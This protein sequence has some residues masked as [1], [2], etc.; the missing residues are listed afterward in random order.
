MSLNN[1]KNDLAV[2]ALNKLRLPDSILIIPDGNGRWAKKEGL[3]IKKGHEEGGRAIGQIL[4]HFVKLNTKIMG[5]WG[6][7]EDNWKRDKTEI[8]NIMRVIES[9]I[10]S[11]LEKLIEN[12]VKFLL[13]G[14]TKR[15]GDEYPQVLLSLKKAEEQTS[16]FEKKTLALFIDYGQRFQLEEFARE[17]KNDPQS[18]TIDLL[19][20]VNRG[21]PLFDMVLRT[22]GEQRLSG[23]GPLAEMA[24]YI[25]IKS[26]L[27][28]MND[29]DF[30]KALI[31]YSRRER[32]F[33]G[34]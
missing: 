28:E 5:I 30:A 17:R 34:R 21:L 16:M 8:D 29:E 27:P 19:S 15:L 2:E 32:R 1:L 33:G 4:E 6:F 18:S 14:N 12:E 31:E 20:K 10:N 9:T 13:V 26:N 24:E 3:E 11:N 25:S 23:F 22:S 7:S